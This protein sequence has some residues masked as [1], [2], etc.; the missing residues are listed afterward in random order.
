MTP[1]PP[2]SDSDALNSVASKIEAN[3]RNRL[4][5]G[6]LLQDAHDGNPKAQSELASKIVS[7]LYPE[8]LWYDL[9]SHAA[10]PGALRSI[11][12]D[13]SQ[14]AC[15]RNPS[16]TPALDDVCSEVL[17]KVVAHHP[18][19][20]ERLDPEDTLDALRGVTARFGKYGLES[21]A[22]IDPAWRI[23]HHYGLFEAAVQGGPSD[24]H[25]RIQAIVSS[26]KALEPIL[27]SQAHAERA[28]SFFDSLRACSVLLATNTPPETAPAVLRD[29]ARSTRDVSIIKDLHAVN[30]NVRFESKEAFAHLLDAFSEKNLV[31]LMRPASSQAPG[32]SF[33]PSFAPPSNRRFGVEIE[34][35]IASSLPRNEVY[36]S[37]RQALRNAGCVGWDVKPDPSINLDVAGDCPFTGLEVVSP[38]MSGSQGCDQLARAL[39]VL[40]QAGLRQNQTT[41]I[42]V[43]VEVE[44]PTPAQLI[45]LLKAPSHPSLHRP[46]SGAQLWAS[47]NPI[48]QVENTGP[49]FPLVRFIENACPSTPKSL[50]GKNYSVNLRPLLT[51]HTV[52]F[53]G[54]SNFKGDLPTVAQQAVATVD[55]IFGSPST[56]TP[57][58]TRSRN[59]SLQA[60]RFDQEKRPI[61]SETRTPPTRA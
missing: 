4:Y 34:G 54:G 31:E 9:T 60:F 46:P 12:L 49:A 32:G 14:A 52:E 47:P 29:A 17:S 33:P 41:G 53:R 26:P 2:L 56:P 48:P 1:L 45:D 25:Q 44:S 37:L 19:D 3:Q 16:L 22:A 27:A 38:P 20:A 24:T 21:T 8:H 13:A 15:L 51:Q 23:A 7:L 50:T 6:K 42:H 5:L 28:Q 61:A 36:D 30:S 11:F 35:F 10:D 43:H 39:R 58:I 59:I 57:A 40:N 55:S 18:D